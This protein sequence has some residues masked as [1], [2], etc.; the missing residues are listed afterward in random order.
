VG[1]DA[2]HGVAAGVVVA[3]DLRE[4]APGGRDR[5]EDPVAVSDAVLV[6]GGADAGFGQDVGE[7]QALVAREAGAE[8]IQAQPGLGFG[9]SGRDDR[10]KF[11]IIYL[12]NYYTK[13]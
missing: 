3:E 8:L 2:R 4:E 1:D 7:R 11:R 6:E 9:D 12:M 13:Y 10:Y 5:A